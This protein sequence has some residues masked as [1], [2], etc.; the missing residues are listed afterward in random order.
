MP[1]PGTGAFGLSISP[2]ADPGVARAIQSRLD[3]A[4]REGRYDPSRSG[5]MQMSDGSS[6]EEFMASDSSRL[7]VFYGRT[8][9]TPGYEAYGCCVVETSEATIQYHGNI[10]HAPRDCRYD[11]L[12]IFDSSDIGRRFGHPC[13]SQV[14][15]VSEPLKSL[16][17]VGSAANTKDTGN[18][19]FRRKAYEVAMRD[20]SNGLGLLDASFAQMD[21]QK[22]GAG[23]LQGMLYSNRAECRL[24]LQQ[25]AGAKDDAEAALACAANVPESNALK[26]KT[27]RR[28]QVRTDMHP[29]VARLYCVLLLQIEILNR[30]CI[31]RKHPRRFSDSSSRSQSRSRSRSS[32]SS[33]GLQYPL[34]RL[35]TLQTQLRPGNTGCQMPLLA[36]QSSSQRITSRKSVK[37]TSVQQAVNCRCHTSRCLNYRSWSSASGLPAVR[38]GINPRGT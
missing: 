34:S 12:D 14:G 27:R 9:S 31:C 17:L 38:L 20:Y 26:Q 30:K 10:F 23:A 6:V 2:G 32:L 35:I 37:F 4:Q 21:L 7:D 18:E 1:F 29:C 24:R 36:V 19:N 5:G 3:A 15:W 8:D 11:L 16:I 33:S 25:W 22:A 28:L 13:P